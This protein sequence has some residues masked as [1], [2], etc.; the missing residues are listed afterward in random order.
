MN[1]GLTI[2]FGEQVENHKGNQQIGAI[3]TNGF[4][5]K[6]LHD[7]KNHLARSNITSNLINL[8]DYLPKEYDKIDAGVLVIPQ[9]IKIFVNQPD[10]MW[11]ELN[12]LTYD[13]HAFMYGSVKQ[14]HARHNLCFADFDQTAD[15]TVGNGT[16]VN[17][18]RLPFLSHVRK[19]LPNLIGSK[20]Y[21]LLA[22][23]NHYYDVNKCGIG[24]H[25][26]TERKIVIGLRF[27]AKFP[28]C[29]YWYHDGNRISQRVDLDLNHGDIYI[30]DEKACGFDWK[31][32]KIPT[33]RHAAGCD[34]YI[35]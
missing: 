9:G 21:N 30:M 28:L 10:L 35:K 5:Y 3:A 16:V 7:I 14:K 11:N 4:S 20:A 6:E 23:A 34:K 29:Y 31:K 22:E 26:D 12:Q 1:S 27:G 18:N 33:L 24:Y 25:G 2:T 19:Y 8:G 32:K 17:F 13:K 15:Y